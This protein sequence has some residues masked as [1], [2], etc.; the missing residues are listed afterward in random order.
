MA[1]LIPGLEIVGEKTGK[2]S[3]IFS[4]LFNL[5]MIVPMPPAQAGSV[6]YIIRNPETGE[7]RTVS[8][9]TKEEA[10]VAASFFRIWACNEPAKKIALQKMKIWMRVF[11]R[12]S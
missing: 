7:I 2:A 6:T 1:E 8:G 4:A 9:G 12:R 5:L 3:G 10:Q 11:M